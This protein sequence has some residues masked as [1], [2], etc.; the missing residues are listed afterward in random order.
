MIET[1]FRSRLGHMKS[2]GMPN[3][4]QLALFAQEFSDVTEFRSPPHSVQRALFTVLAPIARWRGSRD[5]P[6]ALSGCLAPLT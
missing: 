5:V 4:L 1:V 2:K 6:A 3:P